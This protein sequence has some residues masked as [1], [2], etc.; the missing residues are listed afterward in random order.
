MC[1]TFKKNSKRTKKPVNCFFLQDDASAGIR[2]MQTSIVINFVKPQGMDFDILK[3]FKLELKL[4]TKRTILPI[5]N[6]QIYMLA[7]PI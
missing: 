4:K 2:S 5:F 6:I 1:F 3:N 7:T